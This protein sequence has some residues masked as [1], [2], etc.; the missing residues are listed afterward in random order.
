MKKSNIVLAILAGAAAG[1]IIGVLYAPDKGSRTRK[2]LYKKG[3][4]AID[5]LKD[6]AYVLAAY[7]NEV[8]NEIDRLTDKIDA[9]IEKAGF[10]AIDKVGG[11]IK[12]L[13]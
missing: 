12:K 1:A 10:E 13:G 8:S 9:S 4:Q 11:V 6:K 3:G 7:T 2:K 5:D